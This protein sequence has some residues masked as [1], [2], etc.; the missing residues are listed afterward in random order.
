VNGVQKEGHSK[1]Q[2]IEKQIDKYAPFLPNLRKHNRDYSGGNY[3]LRVLK[4]G[5]ENP[6]D[7]HKAAP[8]IS[9]NERAQ[10][11]IKTA[12]DNDFRP[13]LLM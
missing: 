10:L 11:I 7:L 12:F 9:D 1:E 6:Q 8:L 5:N 4:V 3:L 2:W 13:R